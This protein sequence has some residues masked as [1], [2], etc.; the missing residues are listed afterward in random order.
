MKKAA[1]ENFY[2]L[3]GAYRDVFFES[4][5]GEQ[6]ASSVCYEIIVH[7]RLLKQRFMSV[8]GGAFRS[9]RYLLSIIT[10]MKVGMKERVMVRQGFSS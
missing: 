9:Y 10:G 5:S 8:A 7:L 2:F 3:S 6:T 4:G 1:P